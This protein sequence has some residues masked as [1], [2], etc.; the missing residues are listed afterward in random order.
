[1]CRLEGFAVRGVVEVSGRRLELGGARWVNSKAYGV[2]SG[3]TWDSMIEGPRMGTSCSMQ[4]RRRASTERWYVVR[5]CE[6]PWP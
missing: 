2:Q 3:K 1:V 5:E 4:A 6:A